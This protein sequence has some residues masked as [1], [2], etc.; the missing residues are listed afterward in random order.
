MST[1]E[2]VFWLI[3][4]LEREETASDFGVLWTAETRRWLKAG[5]LRLRLAEREISFRLMM[6]KVGGGN[7]ANKSHR[8]QTLEMSCTSCRAE[9]LLLMSTLRWGEAFLFHGRDAHN[10]QR[11]FTSEGNA[12]TG[13]Q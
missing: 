1:S 13:Q 6:P 11:P 7:K 9:A 3:L 12:S 2:A 8:Q 10:T 5:A 4:E